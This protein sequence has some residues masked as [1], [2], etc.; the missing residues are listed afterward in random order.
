MLVRNLIF[1]RTRIPLLNKALN[2][3][4]LRHKAISNNIANVNT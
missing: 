4:S 1:N 3:T 2:M